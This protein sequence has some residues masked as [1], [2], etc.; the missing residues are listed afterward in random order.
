MA[1]KF[2]IDKLNLKYAVSPTNGNKVMAYAPERYY[3]QVGGSFDW[4]GK[5][6]DEAVAK[7]AGIDMTAY[8]PSGVFDTDTKGVRLYGA[9]RALV[10]DETT[11]R[12]ISSGKPP[13][14]QIVLQDD[15]GRWAAMTAPNG[16][17]VQ[18][19]RFD[20]TAPFAE[21]ASD[22]EARRAAIPAPFSGVQ[23]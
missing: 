7:S 19:F 8:D 6:L 11:A 2:A 9:P 23:P 13:S 12:D 1:D 17:A 14:Y 3:P 21:R 4:M 20:P 18:R 22:M 10:S 15:K 16:A 5:Q